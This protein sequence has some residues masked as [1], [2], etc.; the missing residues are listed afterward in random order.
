MGAEENRKSG[1]PT[2]ILEGYSPT[3]PSHPEHE[4][5][6]VVGLIM[7]KFRNAEEARRTYDRNWEFYKLYLQGN[8][9]LGKDLV[10]GQTVRINLRPEDTKRLLAMENL[11]RP[12]ARALVG[13]LC[14]IIPAVEVLPRTDDV[15]EIRSAMLATSFLEYW[16][17]KESWRVKFKQAQQTLQWCGT[18]VWQLCWDR[19]AGRTISWCKT[20]GYKGEEPEIGQPC[21]QCQMQN[22]IQ[23][24][25]QNMQAQQMAMELQQIAPEHPV[26]PPPVTE[27]KPV[28]PL[29]KVNEGDVVVIKHDSRAFYPEPGISDHRKLRYGFL[30]RAVPVSVARDEF[31][32]DT[33]AAEDGIYIDRSVQFYGS[34]TASRTETTFLKDH[35]YI[36]ECYEV[37]SAQHPDGRIIYIV[38]NRI[39][40]QTPNYAWKLLGRLPFYFQWF[41]RVDGEFWGES[42]IAQCWHIQR[43]RNR[44][45]TQKREHRELVLRPRLLNPSNNKLG[46]REIDTTPGRVYTVS[47]FGNM[48]RWL[49]IQP[50]PDYVYAEEDRM[51][52]GIRLQFGVTEQ[53]INVATG[54]QSGRAAALLEAQS[55]ESIAPVII[56]NHEEVKELM[57]GALIF[58]H[59]YYTEDRV[60]LVTGSERVHSIK[61]ADVNLRPGF[62]VSLVEIDSLSKNPA[63][64]QEQARAYL[65]DGLFTDQRTGLPDMR[66]YQKVAGIQIPGLA[67]DVMAAE[68]AYAASIPTKIANG[69]PFQ[70]K[71]WDDARIMVEELVAWLRGPGR[72]QPQDIVFAVGQIYLYYVQLLAPTPADMDITANSTPLGP[73]QQQQQQQPQGPQG[74]L[75]M[76]AGPVAR[77][78]P[79]NQNTVAQNA[80]QNIQ[81]ADAQGEKLARGNKPH[82]G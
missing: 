60:F 75:G 18:A 49:D 37:G 30:R 1:N 28:P 72:N 70:P 74:A 21:P 73:P 13:K 15:S 58:A 36:Y 46:S 56:E 16:A 25:Q 12:I 82:E 47:A 20:C 11:L 59:C 57:R 34:L 66:I 5:T 8:Q 51:T 6:E 61:W 3:R 53:E 78:N 7:E 2:G 77:T 32:D 62:D 45:R 64:R 26:S 22:E 4:E 52:Q 76:G 50:M 67:P 24:Q 38:N 31:T 68:H 43:E 10:T 81:M 19:N 55:S 44:L 41:E 9:L 71:P 48:P 42:P 27:P 40:K 63:I 29:E 35:V 39:K 33:I 69:E 14:R 23:A 54:D 17:D 65:Q 79:I 80:A